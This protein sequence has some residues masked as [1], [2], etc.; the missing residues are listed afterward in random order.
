MKLI[1]SPRI[2]RIQKTALILLIIMGIINYIDRA[3]L[4]IANIEI[5]TEL[6]LDKVEM[7]L[8]LS[9]F[10]LTY[11]F[12]QLPMGMLLDKFGSRIMLGLGLFFWSLA[13]LAG[14]LVHSF[15]QLFITRLIL[16]VSEAP[17]FPAAAK[18]IAEWYNIKERG[19]VMGTFNASAAMG[20]AIAPPLL[21]V[22]MLSFGWRGMFI[23]MGVVGILV[24]IIWYLV[25]RNREDLKL[26]DE[27]ENFLNNGVPQIAKPKAT[28][29][30]WGKLFGS[31]STWG[32]L[33]GFMGIV[34]MIWMYLTWLPAYLT[35]AQVL[36]VINHK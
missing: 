17:Q 3:T 23:I 26:T 12:A 13:Q 36:M 11:A 15:K 28:V 10:S 34:Y 9:A 30:D 31:S 18:S 21:T 14:G 4:S 32:I 2:K 24:A 35:L 8:L 5:S 6:G 20:T 1:K 33:I 19:R 22:L 29:K 27:E 16:G 7:G 25:Y